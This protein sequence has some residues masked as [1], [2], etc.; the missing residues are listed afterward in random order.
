MSVVTVTEMLTVVAEEYL[1][2]Y[3]GYDEE[4]FIDFVKSITHLRC[5]KETT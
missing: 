4:D 1:H 2:E 5:L 3:P